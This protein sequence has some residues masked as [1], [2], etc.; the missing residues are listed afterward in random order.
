MSTCS[1]NRRRTRACPGVYEGAV[2]A[3]GARAATCEETQQRGRISHS[4][5]HGLGRRRGAV[6]RRRH[7][8]TWPT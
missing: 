8:T 5:C 2:T 7:K 1:P 4:G 6:D 3:H